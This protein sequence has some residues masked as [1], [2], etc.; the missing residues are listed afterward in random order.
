MNEFS[1]QLDTIKNDTG[2][3]SFSFDIKDSFF[4][5]YA[6]SDI[7]HVDITADAE[8]K[9]DGDNILL[10]LTIDGKIN[11]LL[12]DICAEELSINITGETNIIIKKTNEELI[13]TDEIVYLKRNENKID[14][15]HL[16]FELIVVNAPTKRQHALDKEGNRNCNK[17]MIDLLNQYTTVKAKKPDPRWNILKNLT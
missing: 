8:L 4:E 1:V 17:K 11:K 6:F 15:Q 12:C 13:S 10:R 3:S 7:E 14:L 16:I 5:A 9:A 2:K